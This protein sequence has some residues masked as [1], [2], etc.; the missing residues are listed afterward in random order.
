MQSVGNWLGPDP[1]WMRLPVMVGADMV[2]QQARF[3]APPEQQGFLAERERHYQRQELAAQRRMGYPL[4]QVADADPETVY[5][6]VMQTPKVQSQSYLS[7]ASS[8]GSGLTVEQIIPYLQAILYTL[9][10]L[11][12]LRL[13]LS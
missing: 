4:G 10:I 3:L 9:L 7:Y 12:L 13:I 8:S 6:D 5:N 1:A 11:Y 2:P